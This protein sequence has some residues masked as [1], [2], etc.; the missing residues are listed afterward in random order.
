MVRHGANLAVED[1]DSRHDNEPGCAVK[2]AFPDK[3]IHPKRLVSFRD[4]AA[5]GGN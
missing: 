1:T 4:F 3:R 2:Q 5:R